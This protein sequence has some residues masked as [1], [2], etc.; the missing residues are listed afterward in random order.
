MRPITGTHVQYFHVCHRKLWLYDREVIMEHTSEAVAGGAL[1]HATSYLE[2]SGKYR[3]ITLDGS[4]ID[5]YDPKAN[6]IHEVKSS[7]KLEHSHIAQLKFYLWLLKQ[8][9]LGT[10][11][12]ILEYPK[13]RQTETVVL[14]E[15]DEKDIG[16]WIS[17]ISLLQQE[18]TPCPPV[19]NKPFCKQC[20]YYEF[21]YTEE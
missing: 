6:V 18:Q 11:T 7:Q 19:I 16:A 17:G 1:L 10:A 2:R 9:G 21:C 8:N 5:F 14:T 4:K 12:G 15:A 13:Q 3:E 20:S